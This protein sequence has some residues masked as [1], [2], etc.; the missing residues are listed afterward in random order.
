MLEVITGNW[1]T[2]VLR[3]ALAILFGVV[4]FVWPEIT[5]TALVLLFGAY[6]FVDG[7]FAIIGAV[8]G[9]RT[10]TRW[11]ALLVQG[12]VGVVAGVWTLFWP[13]ITG[14]ILVYLIAGWAIV[15]GILALVTAVRLRK[16]IEGEWLMALAGVAGIIF[17]VIAA[18]IPSAGAVAIVWMIGTY[19]L[20]LGGLLVALGLRLRSTHEQLDVLRQGGKTASGQSDS[21]GA[22]AA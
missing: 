11:V 22:R 21:A 10:G 19:A 4:A 18:L 13:N 20:I 5:L 1:W 17:G 9:A 7:L 8:R 12:V 2:L 15:T 3:G 14:L 6:A 16:E